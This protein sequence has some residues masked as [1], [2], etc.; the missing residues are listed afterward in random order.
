MR[1]RRLLTATASADPRRLTAAWRVV[2]AVGLLALAATA[3]LVRAQGA[4]AV[5]AGSIS[6]TV[7]AGAGTG[8]TTRFSIEATNTTTNAVTTVDLPDGTTGA[9]SISPLPAGI[10]HVRFYD[11]GGNY[12]PPQCYPAN[13]WCST[14]QDIN[15]LPLGSK[16]GINGTL[17]PDGSIG[18]IVT[19]S[20]DSKTLEYMHVVFANQAGGLN[21]IF[22][23]DTDENGAYATRAYR[24]TYSA[25]VQDGG[26]DFNQANVVV[27]AAHLT[28]ASWSIAA[29]AGS[30]SGTVT[31]AVSSAPVSGAHV[32][33]YEAAA[34]GGANTGDLEYSATTNALGQY[35]LPHVVSSTL[36]YTIFFSDPSGDHYFE[37]YDNQ[38]LAFNANYVHVHSGAATVANA[39]L[40]PLPFVSG[41]LTI[42]GL[43]TPLVGATVDVF[44]EPYSDPVATTTTDGSGNYRVRLAGTGVTRLRFSST[45]FDTEWWDNQPDQA[46]ATTFSPTDGENPGHDAA[47][48]ANAGSLSG[49]VT[50]SVVSTPLQN[51]EV[52]L[53]LLDGTST[54]FTAL[55]AADGKYKLD[56]A[57]IG[58]YKVRFRDQSGANHTEQ[59]YNGR[60]D[61]ASADQVTVVGAV[62]TTGINAAMAPPGIITGLVR[63]PNGSRLPGVSVVFGHP[64]ESFALGTTTDGLGVYSAQ[65]QAGTWI[66][67]FQR[68]GYDRVYSLDQFLPADATPIVIQAG[69]T[70]TLQDQVMQVSG[71][72]PAIVVTDPQVVEPETGAGSADFRVALSRPSPTPVSVHYE[73]VSVSAQPGRDYLGTSG[74]LT[75]APGETAAVVSVVI[76]ADSL[77][78]GT[79]NFLLKLSSPAG[80]TLGDVSGQATIVDRQGPMGIRVDSAAVVEGNTGTTVETFT[81]L[82]AAAPVAGESYSVTYQTADDTATVADNDYVAQSGFLT[83]GAGQQ[84]RT[85]TIT[86]KGDT[87]PEPGEAFSLL[88]GEPSAGAA[89]EDASAQGRILNDD[90][91]AP[92]APKPNVYVRNAYTLE[93]DTGSHLVQLWIQLDQA[94]VSAVTVSWA[95]EDLTA[96]AGKDYTA[97]DGTVTFASGQRNRFI[98]VPVLG[99]YRHESERAFA[100][101]LTNPSG[102]FLGDDQGIVTI[103]DEEQPLEVYVSD[104]AVLAITTPTPR[105]RFAVSLSS[106]PLA[107][108]SVTVQ[109]ATYP[110]AATPADGDYTAQSATLTFAPG[111]R[112]KFVDVSIGAGS[113]TTT[114]SFQLRVASVP[115]GAV[116]GDPIGRA[117]IYHAGDDIIAT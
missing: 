72:V 36:D 101:T 42:E 39:A 106:A 30:L 66:A 96:T 46:S 85:V 9:Y 53:Y 62:N 17:D 38:Q 45:D 69:A 33:V 110:G 19:D 80:A 11:R 108:Q 91:S 94:P 50:D 82:L 52:R 18:G 90:P 1:T 95:T 8:T 67:R 78:E 23:A 35:S 63:D 49:T 2:L 75:F 34:G 74:D 107:G 28:A 77:H 61:M 25:K 68:S 31:D 60:A 44:A 105:A 83:F 92:G 70:T 32:D 24:G 115:A 86:V 113:G 27:T 22:T 84:S 12:G 100:V 81:V 88:L 98:N 5:A 3:V 114:E 14:P 64:G 71:S 21:G 103:A 99:N 109:L 76:G 16:T 56:H 111:E 29:H 97:T 7:S 55:T 112:T 15:L 79:E 116:V 102:A 6:G 20:V 43:G 51:V 37:W 13:D 54:G 57:P 26:G 58:T 10:Y 93:G 73:T 47:L 65:L 48:H 4:T 41:R 117:D 40:E 89:I 104:T 87:K 59:W